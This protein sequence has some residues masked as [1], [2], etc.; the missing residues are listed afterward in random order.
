[1]SPWALRL[2]RLRNR[3]NKLLVQLQNEYLRNTRVVGRPFQLTLEPVNLCNLKCPLCATTTREATLPKGM[4][5]AADAE[6]ILDRFPYTVQLVL[7][8][9][10]EPFLNGEV[11]AIIS[12]AKARGIHVRLE[13]NLTLFDAEQAR[14]LVAAGLDTL[15]VALDGASQETY[16]QYRVGGSFDSVLEHVRLVLDAQRQAGDRRMELEWKFV[17]H[18]GNEH[19]VEAARALAAELG[20]TFHTV[21]IWA[22][23]GEE[24]A[25]RPR[26]A[27]DGRRKADGAPARCHNLWQAVTVN[28]NG[29][30]FPCCSEFTPADRL[31]NALDD[32]FALPW[33]DD[34]VRARRRLNRGPVDCSR[35]HVDKSTRWHERWMGG[36]AQADGP[37]AAR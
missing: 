10:G 34:E 33:N 32:S 15:V 5:K 36:A 22:P 31:G 27:G 17:V 25:W 18:R 11:F 19:E 13:S 1:M 12:A 29:D 37:D 28:F 2:R 30:V 14:R 6:R 35:C 8:N 3:A 7:S 24:E 16:A 21:P 9:W 26:E 4:L 20:M 23:E